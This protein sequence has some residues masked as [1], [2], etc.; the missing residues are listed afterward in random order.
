MKRAQA[1]LF[2]RISWSTA[3]TRRAFGG[4][5]FGVERGPWLRARCVVH[6]GT[7]DDDRCDQ[8]KTALQRDAPVRL[9]PM[10]MG[11][12]RRLPGSRLPLQ[13]S[14]LQRPRADVFGDERGQRVAPRRQ[15]VGMGSPFRIDKFVA[16]PRERR[17]SLQPRD[18]ARF[19]NT[20]RTCSARYTKG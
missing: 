15:P 10:M 1:S 16:W 12:E 9:R 19:A 2:V 18:V 5:E 4:Y 8:N 14:P 3:A 13:V 7:T 20:G 17:S 6:E 11:S